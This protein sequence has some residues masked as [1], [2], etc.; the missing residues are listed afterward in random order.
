MKRTERIK[1]PLGL[2]VS[3]YFTAFDI[4]YNSLRCPDCSCNFMTII[5]GDGTV[6]MGKSCGSVDEKIYQVVVAGQSI[7]SSL[8]PNITSR[9]NVIKLDFRTIASTYKMEKRRWGVRW[10][11]VVP[12]QKLIIV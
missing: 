10:E 1:A 5:D 8:P 12:G 6:L 3:I 11:A 9:S 4:E 7:D 2:V